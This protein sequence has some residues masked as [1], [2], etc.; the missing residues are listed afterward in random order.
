MENAICYLISYIVEA[1]IMW[2]YCNSL[3]IPKHSNKIRG[4]VLVIL[5]SI[6][7]LTSFLGQTWVNIT[8]F[9]LLN[10]FFLLTQYDLKWSAVLFHSA[11]ITAIMSLSELA[12]YGVIS[13]FSPLFFEKTV[14][15]HN[16]ILLG[17]F[18]K[19][20]YFF[21]T[22]ILSYLLRNK[23]YTSMQRD[24]SSFFLGFIPVTSLFI[25]VTY[26]SIGETTSISSKN[27]WLIAL[28][29]LLLLINN[30]MIFG[31]NQI[32]QQKYVEFTE[33]QVLLQKEYDATEYYKMLL[34]QNENQSI[35]IHDI[36]KH[37]QSIALLNDNGDTDKVSAYIRQLLKSSDLKEFSRLCDH[38]LL[39]AI[40]LRY[41]RQ[42]NNKNIEFITDIRIGTTD[43]I[44]DNDLTALFCNLLDNALEATEGI[45]GGYI[46]INTVKKKPTDFIILSIINSC[47]SNPF[48]KN[49]H[50][51]ATNKSDKKKHGFGIKSIR[52]TVEKYQGDIKMYYSEESSSFHTIITLKPLD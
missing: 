6:M 20:I 50:L 5:Y 28:S 19:T 34:Q 17:I 12:V 10:S 25:M 32:N 3:F 42:C 2:Q 46:E 14:I 31:M 40:L 37:L 24:N 47:K 23:S 36:K 11:I 44:Y 22:Y 16:L 41:K 27:N 48:R 1:I 35:L 21:V 8:V 26:I 9:L 7:Y 29:A 49:S 38:E 13:L 30:L 52:K 45:P 4:S 33:M 18:S 51:P 39:N 15:F 43:F